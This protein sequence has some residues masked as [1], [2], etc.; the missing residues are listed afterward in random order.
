MF[1]SLGDHTAGRKSKRDFRWQRLSYP[2]ELYKLELL[3]TLYFLVVFSG[4]RNRDSPRDQMTLIM[5][6]HYA[7]RKRHR[8]KGRPEVRCSQ[9]L[10]VAQGP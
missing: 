5:R 3:T 2:A 10:P 1:L 9:T 8:E 7:G 4:N 6:E